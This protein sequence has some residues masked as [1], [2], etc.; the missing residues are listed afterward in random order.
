LEPA[1]SAVV[2]LGMSYR[3]MAT[4]FGPCD[5]H[6]QTPAL[7]RCGECSR[8]VC[9]D[10]A[11][12]EMVSMLCGPCSRRAQLRAR[13]ARGLGIAAIIVAVAGVVATVAN[14]KPAPRLA[15]CLT[16]F[17]VIDCSD[18]FERSWSQRLFGG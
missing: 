10:C 9:Q 16:E 13:C 14:V 4:G 1:R 2:D 11:A 12:F 5:A 6:L 3:V 18:I 8:R 7:G 17:G 15:L